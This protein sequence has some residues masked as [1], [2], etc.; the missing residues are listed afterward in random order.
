MLS[1]VM[2]HWPK[3]FLT[4][5]SCGKIWTQFVQFSDFL[6]LLLKIIIAGWRHERSYLFHVKGS[7]TTTWSPS[8][9]RFKLTA[10]V[11]FSPGSDWD[12][13]Y[14]GWT[15]NL[16][17]LYC[18]RLTKD[19]LRRTLQQICSFYAL[20]G[21]QHVIISHTKYSQQILKSCLSLFLKLRHVW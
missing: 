11:T 13:C 15:R 5:L 19:D 1:E 2:S 6:F 14:Y 3:Y 9:V 17:N 4:L 21:K 20:L 18:N 12:C 7:H 10:G 16:Y 8:T